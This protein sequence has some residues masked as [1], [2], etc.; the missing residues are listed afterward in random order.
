VRKPERKSPLGRPRHRW[1]DNS[2]MDLKEIGRVLTGL[3]WLR[4]RKMGGSY[5]AG[6]EPL[7]STK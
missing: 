3:I 6:N 2:R 1:E 5:E 7:G 4:I